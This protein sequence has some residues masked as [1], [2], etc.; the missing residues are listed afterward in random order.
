VDWKA[1]RLLHWLKLRSFVNNLNFLLSE[2]KIRL[3]TYFYAFGLTILV[4]Y[5]YSIFNSSEPVGPIGPNLQEFIGVGV[6]LFFA[7]IVSVG[8]AFIQSLT[9][10]EEDALLTLPMEDSS[11]VQSKLLIWIALTPPCLLLFVI[12]AMGLETNFTGI[13]SFVRLPYAYLSVLLFFLII[14]AT[15][16]IIIGLWRR[17]GRITLRLGKYLAGAGVILLLSIPFVLLFYGLQFIV[18]LYYNPII[19]FLL[20]IPISS[21]QIYFIG[22]SD[23]SLVIQLIILLAIASLSMMYAFRFRYE[24]FE[25]NVSPFQRTIGRGEERESPPL[26]DIFERIVRLFRIRYFDLGKGSKAVLGLSYTLSLRGAFL[27]ALLGMMASW[28][29]LFDMT[30]S[31]YRFRF[32]IMMWG[33]AYM[34]FAWFAGVMMAILIHVQVDLELLRTVPLKGTNTLKNLMIPAPLLVGISYLVWLAFGFLTF[35]TG[36]ISV[37]LNGVLIVPILFVN[38]YI[39]AVSMLFLKGQIKT[40][41][42]PEGVQTMSGISSI[43]MMG[44]P[45]VAIVVYMI[46]M[47]I[48]MDLIVGFIGIFVLTSLSIPL[49]YYL[50]NRAAENLNALRPTRTTVQRG[51]ESTNH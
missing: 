13:D 12:V 32:Y 36:I 22:G 18:D 6:F 11:I 25:K 1:I 46:L 35:P 44:F 24:L 10:H 26:P 5:L 45:V 39:C 43:L 27:F 20:V 40:A 8:A 2:R 21:A 50:Y 42:A 49:A 16:S 48:A 9:T 31:I 33:P 38:G 15:F 7:Y 4:T 29:L 19:R 30:E 14:L 41:Y 17:Y 51:S 28:I 3:V 34:V 37:L 47:L 23:S